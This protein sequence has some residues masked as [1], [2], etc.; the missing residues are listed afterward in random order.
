MNKE[1]FNICYDQYRKHGNSLNGTQ[2]ILI[3]VHLNKWISLVGE[4]ETKK[5]LIED[6]DKFHF[7]KF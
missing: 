4:E 1:L 3:E 2:L 6:F 5:I 7:K